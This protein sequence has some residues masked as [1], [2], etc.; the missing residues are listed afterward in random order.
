MGIKNKI[1][2]IIPIL[3]IIFWFIFLLKDNFQAK[4]WIIDDHEILYNVSKKQSYLYLFFDIVNLDLQN[5]HRFRPSYW[6]FRVFEFKVFGYNPFIYYLFH[7]LTISLGFIFLYF[8][9]YI[10]FK[11][12]YILSFL[13]VFLI[14]IQNFWIDI[15]TRLAPTERYAFF[16]I[17]IWFLFLTLIINNRFSLLNLLI[18]SIFTIFSSLVKENFFII[19]PIS[20]LLI[21]IY[22]N[23]IKNVNKKFLI[24]TQF[25]FLIFIL[26][27]IFFFVNIKNNNYDVYSRPTSFLYRFLI[28]KSKIN[29]ILTLSGIVDFLP[30]LLLLVF[31]RKKNGLIISI[32]IILIF[33]SISI[34]NYFIN[35]GEFLA[36]RYYF[37]LIILK[38]Y[39]IPLVFYF[40]FSKIFNFKK[41]NL[42]LSFI[43][44]T[45]FLA[46]IFLLRQNINILKQAVNSN[47]IR[48]NLFNE[49]I[50]KLINVHN[51][52]NYNFVFVF[53]PSF[54][55]QL[56]SINIFL[57]Y[58]NIENK[59]YVIFDNCKVY[60][61]NTLEQ[62]LCLLF[63]KELYKQNS[64]YKNFSFFKLNNK[65]KE[66][67]ILI[68]NND[69]YK[70][71]YNCKFKFN[72]F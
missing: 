24:F 3:T 6:F 51:K 40:S 25:I 44:F 43:F 72:Y 55:E 21:F 57:S 41:N 54:Y 32:L 71:L 34:F 4:F 35:L 28:I 56:Y 11:K 68:Y 2:F 53:D 42:Y 22:F 17:S 63:E 45:Y 33:F 70:D 5:N 67:C 58:Y 29:E 31:F 26:I 15:Y 36:P 61:P 39:F 47:K 27:S 14:S 65:N 30:F 37:P 48:T 66:N 10:L 16:F 18:F 13:L 52:Y 7:F 62:K 1:L 50:N 46:N 19:L 12:N 23:K 64:V 49:Y 20:S 9:F 38:Y 8:S 69:Y 60:S 59:R